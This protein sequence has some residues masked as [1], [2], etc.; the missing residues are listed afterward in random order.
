MREG[1]LYGVD[2]IPGER[3]NAVRVDPDLQVVGVEG[4]R[5]GIVDGHRELRIQQA[6]DP[7]QPVRDLLRR[8]R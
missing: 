4:V 1:Y 7:G 3:V 5:H 8:V 6:A 2:W